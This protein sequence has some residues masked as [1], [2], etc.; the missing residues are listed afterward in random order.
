MTEALKKIAYSVQWQAMIITSLLVFA[1]FLNLRAIGFHYQTVFVDTISIF[2]FIT[3]SI[4]LLDVIQRYYNSKLAF[5]TGNTALIVLLLGITLTGN[6]FISTTLRHP[7]D[8]DYK[9]YLYFTFAY[10]I[11][12]LS[13][14]FSFVHLR[15]WSARRQIREDEAKKLAV[16]QQRDMVQIEIN[17]I[18]QQLKPHFL[19]NSL[20]SINA[21]TMSNPEEAQK[22]VQLLSEF[23]RGSIQQHQNELVSLE[24]EIRHLGLYTEIEKVRFGDRLK[25]EYQLDDELLSKQLP[26][27]ILQPMIENAIKYGLYGNT[28]AVTITISAQ[29][30]E[31]NLLIE[32]SN[33]FDAITQ[34]TNKGTGFGI[35][36]VQ[37][38]LLLIY[39]R[40]NLLK[41]QTKNSIFTATLKIPQL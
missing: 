11:I 33:P 21:L 34:Q 32:V 7:I 27:L 9:G 8:D 19:F 39:Q 13:L 37:R 28:D 3:L 5:N 17:S 15:Q 30:D 24:E 18:Q 20:N 29:M 16:A 36:S 26:F 14:L 38:K 23:M 25:V 1:L 12:I 31:N 22:M 41:T 4:F 40:S 10:R 6:Y 2:A 35:Q